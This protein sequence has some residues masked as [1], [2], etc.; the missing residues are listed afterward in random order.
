[1]I[2]QWFLIK[3]ESGHAK[4]SRFFSF[5]T[6][7]VGNVNKS[8]K[9]KLEAKKRAA[10]SKKDKLL[11]AKKKIQ[12][13]KKKGKGST[14]SIKVPYELHFFHVFSIAF[15]IIFLLSF[16]VSILMHTPTALDYNF[17][18]PSKNN[19]HGQC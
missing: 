17:N 4:K 8:K 19:E 2:F 14:K 5:F 9:D 16:S 18:A 6:S 3:N 7:K 13:K 11:A 1:M 10:Q 12:D 15:Q